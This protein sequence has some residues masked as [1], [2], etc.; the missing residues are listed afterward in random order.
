M[1]STDAPAAAIG[2]TSGRSV[3]FAHQ[4][5]TQVTASH[6]RFVVPVMRKLR[7]LERLVFQHDL[8]QPLE[9]KRHDVAVADSL[10]SE[11]HH[12]RLAAL[13][14]GQPVVKPK[15]LIIAEQPDRLHALEQLH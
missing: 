15:I 5:V 6:R 11:L 3:P 10:S 14:R 4:P 9:G 7:R 2:V 1:T 8:L 13:E 12:G